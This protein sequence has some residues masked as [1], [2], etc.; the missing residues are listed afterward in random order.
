MGFEYE[1]DEED[2]RVLG[3]GEGVRDAAI[4]GRIAVGDCVSGE[5]G[6]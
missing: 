1:R 6:E 2:I 5:R 3:A 4:V